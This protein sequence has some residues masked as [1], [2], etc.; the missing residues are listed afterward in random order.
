MTATDRV[1]LRRRAETHECGTCGRKS[2]LTV[3]FWQGQH[4]VWCP[5]CAATEGFRRKRSDVQRFFDDPESLSANTRQ[6]LVEM[7]RET[8]EEMAAALP[9]ELGRIVRERYFGKEGE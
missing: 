8:I 9:P 1:A 6:A 4:Q 3:R 2:V 5:K 7:H